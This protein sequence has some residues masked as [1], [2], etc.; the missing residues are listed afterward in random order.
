MV[1]AERGCLA[2]MGAVCEL[3][4][5]G[6]HLEIQEMELLAGM[7]QDIPFPRRVARMHRTCMPLVW[8]STQTVFQIPRQCRGSRRSRHFPPAA[9]WR[10]SKAPA[11][12]GPRISQV[13]VS[14][15][16]TS[17]VLAFQIRLLDQVSR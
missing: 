12:S 4:T 17:A 13:P 10:I 9:R 2:V 1:A 15:V 16:R 3:Q 6:I 14:G 11:A 5:S 7:I 8:D